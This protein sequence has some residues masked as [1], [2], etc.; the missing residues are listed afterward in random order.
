ME[1]AIGVAVSHR[2]QQMSEKKD[3]LNV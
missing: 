1:W 3:F 2:R